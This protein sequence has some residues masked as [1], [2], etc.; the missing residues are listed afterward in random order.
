MWRRLLTLSLLLSEVRTRVNCMSVCYDVVT[1]E[2]SAD[3]LCSTVVCGLGQSHRFI[4]VVTQV[5]TE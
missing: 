3:V 4:L 2:I 5:C 1:M